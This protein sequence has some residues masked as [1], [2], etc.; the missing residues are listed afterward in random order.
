[1]ILVINPMITIPDLFLPLDFVPKV[2]TAVRA[3]DLR[4]ERTVVAQLQ[5]IPAA[6]LQLLLDQIEYFRLNNCRMMIVDIVLSPLAFVLLAFL[7]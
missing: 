2:P 5:S 1:M 3:D 7:G 6:F 4:R